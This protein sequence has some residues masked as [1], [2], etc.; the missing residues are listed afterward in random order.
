MGAGSCFVITFCQPFCFRWHPTI[1][2]WHF[3]ATRSSSLSTGKLVIQWSNLRSFLRLASILIETLGTER[4][5]SFCVHVKSNSDEKRE[6]RL[7]IA[8]VNVFTKTHLPLKV[9]F[10]LPNYFFAGKLGKNHI[11]QV[12]HFVEYTKEK[13]HKLQKVKSRRK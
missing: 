9:K 4:C 11:S 8:C 2:K 10:K 3:L 6:S 7:V 13:C 5:L 1:W 12:N